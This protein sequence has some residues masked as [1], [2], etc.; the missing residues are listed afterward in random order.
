MSAIFKSNL[1]LGQAASKMLIGQQNII[2]Q[3]LDRQ[4]LISNKRKRVKKLIK[5]HSPNPSF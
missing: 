5:L 2:K 4:K 1:T 3:K